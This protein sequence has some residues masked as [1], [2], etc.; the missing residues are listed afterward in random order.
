MVSTSRLHLHPGERQEVSESRS[1]WSSETR[2]RGTEV[3][4]EGR[5]IYP[6]RSHDSVVPF[7]TRATSYEDHPQ[8][9]LSPRGPLPTRSTPHEVHSPTRSTPTRPIVP[10]GPLS[11]EVHCQEVHSSTRSTP[12]RST[13]TGPIVPRGPLPRDPLSYEVDSH[14]VHSPRG[15]FLTR[16]TP[17]RS[18]PHEVHGRP[19][20]RVWRRV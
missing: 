14:E 1:T 10:R 9:V 8:D 4:R 2:S 6:L 19:R 17:K 11:H 7:P 3:S 16:P 20:F 18:T 12:K 5:W 15:P 13:P